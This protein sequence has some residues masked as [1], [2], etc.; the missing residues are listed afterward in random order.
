MALAV[1]LARRNV[2]ERTGGPFGAAVFR[3]VSGALVSVGVN[4][5]VPLSNSALHAEVVALMLA[6]QRS[7]SFSLDIPAD[8]LVLYTSCEPCAM[9]LGAI[10]WSG[11]SRVVCGAARADASEIG[12]DEGPVFAESYAYLA[13]RGIRIEHG[14]LRTEARRVLLDYAAID[15]AVYNA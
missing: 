12:F 1:E 14:V 2:A 9:C 10:W 5:V 11:I 6:E 3:E 7:G 15:G 8:P 4:R 13:E